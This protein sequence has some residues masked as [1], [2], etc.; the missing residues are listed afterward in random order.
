[1]GSLE[2]ATVVVAV[3]Q[4]AGMGALIAD[5]PTAPLLSRIGDHPLLALAE[6]ID[7]PL[8]DTDPSAGERFVELR[9]AA[10][11]ASV[12]LNEE[13][14]L[15]LGQGQRGGP[16]P[17]VEAGHDPRGSP[18]LKELTKLPSGDA[19]AGGHLTDRLGREDPTSGLIDEP[20]D[21]TVGELGHASRKGPGFQTAP[22]S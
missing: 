18:S 21:P 3:K 1:M 4:R 2:R 13:A 6:A 17:R 20:L 15:F 9:G 7:L 22:R 19:P 11:R 14:L 10:G 5:P 12:L 16:P 8:G